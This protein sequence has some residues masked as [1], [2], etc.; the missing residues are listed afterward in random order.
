MSAAELDR[1][2]QA[3][4][5]HDRPAPQPADPAVI[6]RLGAITCVILFHLNLWPI[7]GSA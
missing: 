1:I 6:A 2:A 5:A 4:A 3:R 7:I